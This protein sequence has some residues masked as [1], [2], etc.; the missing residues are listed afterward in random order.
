MKNIIAALILSVGL[1]QT[2]ATDD[3]VTIQYEPGYTVSGRAVSIR[4]DRPYDK[5]GTLIP[6]V[7][8]RLQAIQS[9]ETKSFMVPDAS[10]ITIVAQLDGQRLEASSCHT[11]FEANEKVV[12]RSFGI[13]ALDGQTREEALAEEPKDFL[14]FRRLWEEAL[15][16][17]IKS[18]N[19]TFQPS[20]FRT[21]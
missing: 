11:I 20:Q 2:N 12:A 15:D 4:I 14:E 7:F 17:S 9:L 16:M 6:D 3:C 18:V 5:S 21:E 10:H 13:T 1:A 8:E 19:Q